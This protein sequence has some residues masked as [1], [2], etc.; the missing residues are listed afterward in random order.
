MPCIFLI[1]W[2]F[3]HKFSKKAR[4]D[5]NYED[6]VNGLVCKEISRPVKKDKERS[7][8]TLLSWSATERASVS[9]PRDKFN[10]ITTNLF[11]RLRELQ[12]HKFSKKARGDNNY[13]DNVNGLVCKEISRPVK[14]DKKRSPRTLLSWSATERASVSNPRDK[15]NSI[16]DHGKKSSMDDLGLSSPH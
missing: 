1:S 11:A 10:S 13:E 4:G 3:R 6:N 5:N 7:P 15:F 14:K 16:M 2:G 8:R 9:N 12:R